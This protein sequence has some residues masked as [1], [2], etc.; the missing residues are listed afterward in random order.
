MLIEDGD[1]FTVTVRVF[2]SP[3]F[4][5]WVMGFG[6]DMQVLSPGSTREAL[7]AQARDV[8]SLYET[9]GS[10]VSS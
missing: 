7:A 8:L 9:N 2:E 4:L 1:G 3:T 6:K 10:E 5:S